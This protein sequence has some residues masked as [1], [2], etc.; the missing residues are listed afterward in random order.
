MTIALPSLPYQARVKPRLIDF[1]TDLQPALGGPR[2]FIARLGARFALDVTLPTLDV[3]TFAAWNA[4]RLKSRATGV[5]LTMAFPQP[6]APAT[7]FGTPLVNGGGQAGTSLSVRG[8][9]ASVAIPQGLFFSIHSGGRFYMHQ[10]TDAQSAS[11]G[12]VAALSIAPML[13]VNPSDGDAINLV[14]PSLQGFLDGTTAD[15]DDQ[16]RKWQTFSFTLTES[17]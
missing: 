7:G 11:T 9:T 13:R 12:G 10:V 4:A 17:A 14:S 3:A 2:Q 8:L 1:G 15:W 6:L 16:F 5:E